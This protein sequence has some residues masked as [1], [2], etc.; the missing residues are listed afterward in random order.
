[1][2]TGDIAAGAVTTAK[3]AANNIDST[4]TKDALIADYTEVTIA[5]GDSLLLGDV[6]D[7]GNTKRDTVQGI[8]DLVPAGGGAWNI[9]GTA[10]A[11]NSASLTVTGLNS[12]YDTYAIAG[13]D[14]LHASD[15][16]ALDFRVGDSSGIDSGA[17]DYD[18]HRADLVS[19]STSYVAED[20][21][22]S[23]HISLLQDM[24]NATGEGGGF[25]IYLHRP[26]DGTTMPSISGTGASSQNN[27]ARHGGAIIFGRRAAVI[28]LDRVEILARS[29]NLTSGRLTVWGIAHA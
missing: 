2:Q 20:S 8:L 17:S 26:G 4:L 15:G 7:S 6:G 13:T 10:V 11:S 23:A 21:A 9:I 22:S 29:G 3:I 12:T 14:I 28:T 1:V 27:P 18:W 19:D 16:Q 24:G 5:T 25:L